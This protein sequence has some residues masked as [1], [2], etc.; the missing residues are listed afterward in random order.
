MNEVCLVGC[1]RI[2]RLHARN[3]SAMAKL[4][5]CSRTRASAERLQGEFKG[6]GVFER[7]EDV[8]NSPRIKAVVLATPPQVHQEQTVAALRAGKSVL[9]EKPMC[10]TA[11]E[12]GAIEAALK[13]RRDCFLMVAENYYYK[14]SLDLMKRLI[15]SGSIGRIEVVDVRKLFALEATG[16]KG[17]CGAL[18]EGGVHFVALISALFDAAP[19]MVKAE[20]PGRAAG[21]AE[22]SSIVDLAY[23]GGA[24]ARL[25]Y[26]WNA[27]SITRG[28]FQHSR[29]CGDQG[30]IT[31]ESNGIY[32]WLNS[33]KR[34]RLFVPGFSDLMGYRRMSRDF[35]RC[36]NDPAKQ[37]YSDFRKARRDLG[38]VFEAYAGLQDGEDQ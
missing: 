1:G 33:G 38:I 24:A 11:G 28:A 21:Q 13:E 31:F 7:L 23:A 19:E 20:F 10:L 5:F 3:L 16:W 37:P 18:L 34:K 26:A 2:G 36:L 29:I 22:R 17:E 27:R 35:I 9:V 15:A 6:G 8:L 14:P 4:S 12:V 30:K 25:R 32:V